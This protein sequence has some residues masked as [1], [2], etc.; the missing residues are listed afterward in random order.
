MST[1]RPVGL[2]QLGLAAGVAVCHFIEDASAFIRLLSQ[3]GFSNKVVQNI[4][5]KQ[6]TIGQ[7]PVDSE[8]TRAALRGEQG[9]A[10]FEDYRGIAVASAYGTIDVAG[11]GWVILSEIDASFACIQ[12]A[13]LSGVGNNKQQYS[14]GCDHH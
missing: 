4:R 14:R 13:G 10:V 5:A 9:F 1:V 11:L 12:A 8:G 7:L 6:T 3:S 2:G